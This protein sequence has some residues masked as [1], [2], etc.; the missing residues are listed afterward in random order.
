MVSFPE[1]STRQ[2]AQ[3]WSDNL[4]LPYTSKLEVIWDPTTSNLLVYSLQ[5]PY[6]HDHWDFSSRSFEETFGQ[7]GQ[8][9]T[10]LTLKLDF[11]E[12]LCGRFR[13]SCHVWVS[14]TWLTIRNKSFARVYWSKSPMWKYMWFGSFV[15]VLKRSKGHL[16]LSILWKTCKK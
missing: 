3:I 13:N 12:H 10:Q 14:N 2:C 5:L 11:P 1:W 8:E 16:A 9:K 6:K 7:T 4:Q 15:Q